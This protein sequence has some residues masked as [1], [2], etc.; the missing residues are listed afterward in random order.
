MSHPITDDFTMSIITFSFYFS[1][2][3]IVKVYKLLRIRK[4]RTRN[5]FYQFSAGIN[6]NKREWRKSR[7]TADESRSIWSTI[8][9]FTRSQRWGI[10]IASL[11][12][13]KPRSSNEPRFGSH[14]FP[15]TNIFVFF[16]FL[17][18]N[19]F[20]VFR[21]RNIKIAHRDISAL[22]LA[23]TFDRRSSPQHC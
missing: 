14:R 13:R 4:P 19:D 17:N 1:S 2:H 11:T 9:L 21:K 6:A 18:A 12:Y 22:S 16:F 15:V 7:V 10:N 5:Y 23:K 3:L 20:L 8:S